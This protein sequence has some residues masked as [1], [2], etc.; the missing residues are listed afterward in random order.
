MLKNLYR[1]TEKTRSKEYSKLVL[2]SIEELTTKKDG[3]SFQQ[4]IEGTYLPW[5]KTQVKES[6][7]LNRATTIKKHFSYFYKMETNEIEPIHVQN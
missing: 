3:V 2:A 1:K 7:Y 4:F 5:Y 6:T